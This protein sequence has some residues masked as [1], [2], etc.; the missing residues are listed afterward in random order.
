MFER[1]GERLKVEVVKS[2][3][4]VSGEEERILLASVD[5][6]EPGKSI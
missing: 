6:T 2:R 3:F 5:L 1:S 4:E